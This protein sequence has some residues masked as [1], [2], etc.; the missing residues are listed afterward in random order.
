MSGEFD[1]SSIRATR[2]TDDINNSWKGIANH[3]PT[4]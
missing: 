1:R 2:K 3:P 4:L